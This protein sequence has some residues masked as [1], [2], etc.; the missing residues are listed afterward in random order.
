MRKAVSTFIVVSV[1]GIL[2]GSCGATARRPPAPQTPSAQ[3]TRP[4]RTHES[5]NAT[6]WMQTAVE[7]RAAALQAY[8][9]ARLALDT[10]IADPHW[11]AATEQT[12][13]ASSK[14]LAIVL[15]LDETVLDNSPFEARMIADS[16]LEK[17]IP[18][19]ETAWRRWVGEKK[20][21]AI[22][23][24]ADFLRYAASRH[25]TPMY[26][27]NRSVAG[28]DPKDTNGGE[29]DT[30]AVLRKLNIPVDANGETLLMVGE[31]GWNAS[32]KGSR[33]TFVAE[34]YRILLL[35]GDNFED[36]VSV[37]DKSMGARD[38]L[39]SRYDGWWG[40]KWIMMPNPTYGSWED[41]ITLGAPRNDP[42][43]ALA[44]K[45]TALRLAR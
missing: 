41:A 19:D 9:S 13:E 36:F 27:T 6:L 7:Y 8:H 44:R 39:A 37:P 3:S 2:S 1:A 43:A 17:P 38:A 23:G 28:A 40:S 33:R 10:A 45:Y 14:P 18:Y 4:L 20:A 42:A 34:K 31:H 26:I 12:D 5:L 35:M 24:A 16:T 22:P 25:V 29:R 30:I 11:T 32:D 21:T 15:D